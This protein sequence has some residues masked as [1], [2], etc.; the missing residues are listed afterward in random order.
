MDRRRFNKIGEA[1]PLITDSESQ[2]MAKYWWG[3]GR[4]QHILFCKTSDGLLLHVLEKHFLKAMQQKKSVIL[5]KWSAP[6]Q[7]KRKKMDKGKGKDLLEPPKE[8]DI[9]VLPEPKRRRITPQE[10]SPGLPKLPLEIIFMILM[11]S[12]EPTPSI[13]KV[14]FGLVKPGA[15]T[16]EFSVELSRPKLVWRWYQKVLNTEPPLDLGDLWKYYVQD[17]KDPNAFVRKWYAGF[18]RAYDMKHLLRVYFQTDLADIMDEPT[19]HF[20]MIHLRGRTVGTGYRDA[21]A[22]VDYQTAESYIS[23]TRARLLKIGDPKLQ[24]KPLIDGAITK[25]ISYYTQIDRNK[26]KYTKLWNDFELGRSAI[27]PWSEWFPELLVMFHRSSE[28]AIR[29]IRGI[30]EAQPF[31]DKD[32]VAMIWL[33]HVSMNL[34]SGQL[35]RKGLIASLITYPAEIFIEQSFM[36]SYFLGEVLQQIEKRVLRAIDPSISKEGINKERDIFRL[37]RRWNARQWVLDGGIRGLTTREREEKEKD[38]G[39]EEEEEK[40]EPEEE[41][42]QEDGGDDDREYQRKQA[43]RDR[44]YARLRREDEQE[45]SSSSSSTTTAKMT[46]LP[47]FW[48]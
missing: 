42:K 38:E 12:S 36:D 22:V 9:L 14:I 44:K 47:Q 26:R 8:S 40:K 11:Q 24:L 13:R 46:T 3:G 5:K 18:V 31:S 39:K 2:G 32:Y 37:Q 33:I 25:A 6:I 27:E 45:M 17:M 21:E 15:E 41:A 35:K 7:G 48:N 10:E 34:V 4:H 1:A 23:R 28:R 20:I 16:T 43:A 29:I 30:A 19:L